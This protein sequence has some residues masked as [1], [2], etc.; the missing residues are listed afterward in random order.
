MKQQEMERLHEIH[1]EEMK[2]LRK[3][4]KVWERYQRASDALPTKKL[5][6]LNVFT[7]LLSL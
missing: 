4:K 5:D 6:S 1:Q 7:Y 2:K 3:E